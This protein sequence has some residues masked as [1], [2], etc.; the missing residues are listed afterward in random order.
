MIM[1]YHGVFSVVGSG[2][3]PPWTADRWSAGHA[4]R[5][6][7]ESGWPWLEVAETGIVRRSNP[8]FVRGNAGTQVRNSA[9]I[10]AAG[11]FEADRWL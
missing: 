2:S 10:L 4:R 7:R 11:R 9:I 8:P 3:G 1:M 5:R 6:V